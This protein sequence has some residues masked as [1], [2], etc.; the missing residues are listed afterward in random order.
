MNENVHRSRSA[1]NSYYVPVV[2]FDPH[3]NPTS[4]RELPVLGTVLGWL[5]PEKEL[6]LCDLPSIPF[7]A[8]VGMGRKI[9][10]GQ[11]FGGGSAT[12][13]LLAN[14][15]QDIAVTWL[16]LS[17]IAQNGFSA[18]LAKPTHRIVLPYSGKA[19]AGY[20]L[21]MQGINAEQKTVLVSELP[22]SILFE[23]VCRLAVEAIIVRNNDLQGKVKSRLRKDSLPENL[24]K[25]DP[26]SSA[27]KITHRL[28]LRDVLSTFDA[29][30]FHGF[31]ELLE[32]ARTE[33]NKVILRF[34]PGYS[35]IEMLKY[36]FNEGMVYMT[37]HETYTIETRCCAE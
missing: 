15:E 26:T 2:R 19:L 14:D 16:R 8:F 17:T 21:E 4:A 32:A 3:F 7:G 6:V 27:K 10:L 35:H 12:N 25:L 36:G 9:G 5:S 18:M 11:L 23:K 30:S 28:T 37:E 33:F 34:P 13:L 20:G 31:D 29:R 1:P 22:R 24:K